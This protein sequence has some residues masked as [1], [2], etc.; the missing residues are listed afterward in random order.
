MVVVTIL[1]S[2]GFN[3]YSNSKL[4]TQ[5]KIEQQYLLQVTTLIEGYFSEQLKY[6]DD[7]NE[8]L[9]S[10]N[11]QFLTPK[12]FY[13]ISYSLNQDNSYSVSATLNTKSLE[14]H[15]LVIKST[16]ELIAFDSEDNDISS[17]CWD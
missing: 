2:F 5:G 7:L 3:T 12:K 15:R 8:I 9:T 1:M 14:C 11:G 10:E 6:P 13:Q 4:K 16:G 17:E